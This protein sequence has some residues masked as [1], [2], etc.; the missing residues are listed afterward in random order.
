ME[1]TLKVILLKEQIM[2]AL[3][4]YHC[5]FEIRTFNLRGESSFLP[6]C[7]KNIEV[8]EY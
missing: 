8:T 3:P 2:N 6:L 7:Q 5:Q 4:L 1:N